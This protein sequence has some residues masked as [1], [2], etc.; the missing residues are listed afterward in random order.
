MYEF[1]SFKLLGRW[2]STL[3]CDGSA[4]F[5]N[6]YKPATRMNADET[7]QRRRV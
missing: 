7:D 6:A 4:A 2:L 1:K 3:K 5:L